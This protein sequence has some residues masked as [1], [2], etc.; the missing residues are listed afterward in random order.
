MDFSIPER[1]DDGADDPAMLISLN[2]LRD[3]VELPGDLDPPSLAAR[4]TTTIAEVEGVERH[5][6]NCAGLVAG[7]VV[8]LDSI[9]GE[10]RLQRVIVD[11]GGRFETLSTAPELSPGALVVYA[12]PG[13]RVGGNAL[14]LTDPAGRASAG[15]IV[16]GQAAGLA[17]V[18]AHALFLPPETK[19]GAPIDCG[20]FD[21]WV[22]EIDN[23]SITHRP[24]LW[25]HYGVAREL[26]AMLGARLRPYDVTPVDELARAD[27]PAIPIEIDDSRLCP[28]YTGLMLTGLRGGARA[29]GRSRPS[30]LWM[31]ARLAMVGMRPIDLVVDLTNYVMAELGQP[32]HAFDGSR[33]R[34]IQVALATPGG[35]FTTLD[36][37]SRVLPA[38][39]LMIQSDRRDVALAGIMGG[40]E[41]EVGAATE[42]VLLESANFDAATIRRAA[43]A[44]GHRTEASARFEKSLDPAH[45]VLG[46]CRFHR[47][48]RVELPGLGLASRLSDCY[49]APKSAAAIDLDCDFAARII[50]KP[51]T[52][53]EIV[54]ILTPL[55]FT[56][57]PAPAGNFL[58][59]TPPSWRATKDIEIDADLI[60]EVARYVGYDTIEPCLPR[61]AARHFEESAEL[62]IERATLDYL[63]V[64]GEFVEV[65]GYIWYDDAWLATL[66]FDPG[67][68]VTLLNPAGEH[69]R[70][71][72]GSLIPGLLWMAEINRQHEDR[73]SI[74]EI[75]SVFM[76][77]RA[78]V[79]ESQ[80]RMLGLVTAQSGA[81]EEQSAWDRLRNAL[82]GWAR[83]VLEAS[84]SFRE[85]QA[86]QPWQDGH[87]LAEIRLEGESVGCVSIVP[88]SLKM[89]IDERLKSWSMATA[90]LNLAA[91]ARLLGRHE[92]LPPPPRHPQVELDFSFLAPAARRY[93]EIE[94]RLA[95]FGHPF[96][97]GM[98]FVDAYQGGSI[99]KGKRGLTIRARVGLENRTLT[100][101]DIGA[102]QQAMR[103]FVV[104]EGMELRG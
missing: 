12:P 80:H 100:E 55:G 91:A 98:W 59:V 70:R 92:R 42:T 101:S 9:S 71:L 21:D 76:P 40:A 34:N 102:F 81:K 75:G 77:G 49:P 73:F 43:T 3:F 22:I 93:A 103:E 2:W 60:E 48:A 47:L 82:D 86:R 51:V 38:G 95:S 17:S 88:L 64:G 52:R 87:R 62:A 41:T 94:G 45:T 79:E 46:I 53:D 19:P 72:R 78:R 37:V 99:P 11:A 90:E 57:N 1:G 84:V 61:V 33:V 5:Q 36:G 65:H 104:R 6:G 85:M 69:C 74:A 23:K 10:A 16:A 28:R 35:T 25:G 58:R 7:Q 4:F 39:A 18:G 30:P 83:Q 13:A 50:G 15:M 96:L 67:P 29:G 54:R 8:S 32:M 26:A 24:D 27:L 20:L 44:M 63:C 66:G 97:R 31:Q 14:G 68:C 89:R 56:C